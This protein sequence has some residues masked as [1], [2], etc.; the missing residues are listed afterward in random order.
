M[1]LSLLD[2]PNELL[3]AVIGGLHMRGD[4]WAL[5]T[6]N[7]RLSSVAIDQLY[8]FN[9]RFEG[10]SALPWA[11]EH[12]VES[13]VQRYFGETNSLDPPKAAIRDA[14]KAASERGRD[15]VVEL[16]LKSGA[17]ESCG[18]HFICA[19]AERGHVSMVRLYL[20]HRPFLL[21]NFDYDSWNVL[22]RAAEFGHLDIVKLLLSKHGVNP[23]IGKPFGTTPL[24]CAASQGHKEIVRMLIEHGADLTAVDSC[25]E[26]PLVAA[27][28]HNNTD[29]ARMLLDYESAFD[30]VTPNKEKAWDIVLRCEY[31]EM[32]KLLLRHERAGWPD[33]Q[34]D[35]WAPLYKAIF[36]GQDEMALLLM[37]L[38]GEVNRADS[39]GYTPIMAAADCKNVPILLH[40]IKRGA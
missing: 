32:A 28:L 5:A 16:L 3:D 10:C 35:N 27:M 30:I 22:H 21:L 36:F 39:R 11:A 14:L 2:L 33:R 17:M 26:T 25:R 40:L 15:S 38:D 12:G 1:A 4:I 7:R 19:A 23:S 13:I 29:L 24:H 37:D 6:T 9:A 18:Q 34:D 8:K 31:V 20:D